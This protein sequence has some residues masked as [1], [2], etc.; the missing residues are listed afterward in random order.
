MENGRLSKLWDSSHPPLTNEPCKPSGCKRFAGGQDILRRGAG[1]L[2]LR[3][4]GRARTLFGPVFKLH[5]A[6]QQGPIAFE[7]KG[8]LIM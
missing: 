3:F 6:V 5:Q 8:Q 7:T 2:S 1:L 4:Q